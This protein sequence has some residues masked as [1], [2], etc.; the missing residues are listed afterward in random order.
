MDYTTLIADKNTAGSIARWVNYGQLDVTQILEEAQL[1]IYQTLRVRE[2]KVVGATIAVATGD[3]NVSLPSDFLDPINFR[4]N[5][6]NR[7]LL[8]D[9]KSVLNA[10]SLDTSGAWSQSAPYWYAIGSSTIEFDCAIASTSAGNYLF[11]YYGKPALLGVSNTTN[12]LTSR[13]PTLLRTACLAQ[14]ADFMKNW[15]AYEEYAQRLLA[16]IQSVQ[17]NDDLAFRGGEV[18]PDYSEAW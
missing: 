15:Q 4:D 9:E 2:M 12:F 10:R 13:Y 11:E 17:T 14:A 1:L 18:A 16:M 7:L 3:L 6:N 8:K 5:Q